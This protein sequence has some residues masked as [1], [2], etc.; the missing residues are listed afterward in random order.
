MD[1]VEEVVQ[2][3]MSLNAQKMA[4]QQR[5]RARRGAKAQ[6]KT[7]GR[8]GQRTVNS[9]VRKRRRAHEKRQFDQ[10]TV[11]LDQTDP[12]DEY[13]DTDEEMEAI[14]QMDQ[15][16]QTAQEP[17]LQ[18][19]AIEE[20]PLP[21]AAIPRIRP[22][23]L[24]DDDDD[25][26]NSAIIR[27][28]SNISSPRRLRNNIENSRGSRR[29]GFHPYTKET[30]STQT[31]N[32]SRSNLPLKTPIN[33]PTKAQMQTT[34]T[35]H[36]TQTAINTENISQETHRPAVESVISREGSP[37]IPQIRS[38]R[39]EPLGVEEESEY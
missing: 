31:A 22:L 38:N 4:A 25:G 27:K 20:T 21:E 7:T 17:Q 19:D 29:A 6:T 12:M 9:G 37:D 2:P 39:I 33:N 32:R 30:S 26:D 14:D 5:Q 10:N 15:I 1:D 13:E 36:T 18:Q 8:Q 11:Q 34:D 28:R 24:D 16:D 35:E 3:G 23:N